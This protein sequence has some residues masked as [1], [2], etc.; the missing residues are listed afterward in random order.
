CETL[1]E[2]VTAM[3]KSEMP[4][5]FYTDHRFALVVLCI[6]LIMPMS[7]SKEISIQ[8]YTSVLGTLAAT[9]LS[10][11]IIIKYCTM[12]TVADHKAP[13]YSS[14]IS[15]WASMFSVIPTICFGFQ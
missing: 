3:P 14:G 9:Y 13:L 15:S 1:Y 5:H 10:V 7:I 12:P 2:L 6:F 8:K 11:A 4:Y